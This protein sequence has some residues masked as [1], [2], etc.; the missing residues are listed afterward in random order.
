MMKS[1]SSHELL[2]QYLIM[3]GV[4]IDINQY[5][6]LVE[7]TEDQLLETG[8]ELFDSII[9]DAFNG[10]NEAVAYIANSIYK[11]KKIHIGRQ[12]KNLLKLCL[13]Y[14]DNHLLDRFPE[15]V[16]SKDE[17]LTI[18]NETKDKFG[19]KV[20]EC[21]QH[22]FLQL[23][24][25]INS[26]NSKRVSDYL[27]FLYSKA[28]YHNEYKYRSVKDIFLDNYRFLK[29]ELNQNE[30]EELERIFGNLA[31]PII[32]KEAVETFNKVFNN[33]R[34]NTKRYGA[35]TINIDQLIFDKS[36]SIEDFFETVHL[37]INR[38]YNI[39]DNHRAVI[40]KI[41]NIIHNN[42]NIKWELFS[43]ITVY[44]ENFIKYTENR[45]YYLPEDICLDFLKDK[46]KIE[47]CDDSKRLLSE[48]FSDSITFE[49]FRFSLSLDESFNKSELDDFRNIYTGLEFVDCLI[50]KR[51]KCFDNT[52]E[53]A[54]IKNDNEL[55]LV[56]FK[57]EIDDRKIP[58]PVCGSLKVSGNSYTKV[59][60]KSWEC[61]N[62]HCADRSKTNRGKRYSEKSNLMQETALIRKQTDLIPKELVSK[63]RRDLVD[64]ENYSSLLEMIN[65]YYSFS[66]D[67]SL[68]V[69]FN[70][71][72]FAI[73]FYQVK[74][75]TMDFVDTSEFL[76]SFD[77]EC[78]SNDNIIKELFSTRIILNKIIPSGI[79]SNDENY[80]IHKTRIVNKSCIDFLSNINPNSIHH[81]IT[82][83]P[84]YNA[85]EYSQWSNL[86][87][88]LNEMHSMVTLSYQR[89]VPG[90]VFTFNIG[91]IFG[92][93]NIIVKS[94]MGERRIALGAYLTQIFLQVGFELLD[95]I[96]WDKGETQSNR[97]KNDG[98]YTPYYQRPANCYEHIFLFK[99]PGELLL[100]EKSAIKANIVKFPP[101]I[102]I[103]SKG[104]NTFGH[105]APF[106]EYL[107][108]ISIKTFTKEGDIVFDPF[109]G[110]GTTVKVALSLDRIGVG[111]E[112]DREYYELCLKKV[113]FEK[114]ALR[115]LYF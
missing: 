37:I 86:Y 15:S 68:Y 11:S 96:I 112:I 94:T 34:N 29:K 64:P 38:S 9:V 14:N 56:F 65:S 52:E 46:Y 93:P 59:G 16:T 91:D 5:I 24:S 35:V 1:Q 61:K 42:K 72:E 74:S 107:P 109:L 98:N 30:F 102:K 10:F 69:N 8:I 60:I 113:N 77:G 32:Y 2:Y 106:P 58:C 70:K 83:P 54:F 80:Q 19:S 110:S 33:I 53:V 100:N 36:N 104:D 81:M 47:V 12:E 62:L 84:Y 82:S 76:D 21:R 23:Q 39:I 6:N 111:T 43:N 87:S 78:F 67:K 114:S 99:K 73:P 25:S 49:D 89:L 108:E 4:K 88:Y 20:S 97:H 85:R 79:T 22:F 3:N 75:R 90:G 105:T 95:N 45:N 66:G 101:V 71:E 41:G 40:I 26:N 63:W 13:D 50:L 7:F 44:A 27:N 57:H 28:I 92:N 115:L 48:Y 55:L 17:L 31:E 18:V 103:N 51:D